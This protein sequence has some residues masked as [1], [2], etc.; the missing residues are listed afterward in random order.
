MWL[1]NC[2]SRGFH[3]SGSCPFVTWAPTLG[4]VVELPRSGALRAE[5]SSTVAGAP[6]PAI[7]AASS[8]GLLGTVAAALAAC[9]LPASAPA[10]PSAPAATAP[11]A[12]GSSKSGPASSSLRLCSRRASAAAT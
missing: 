1:S 11:A 6:T 4:I 10:A 3:R 5:G 7:D 2:G 9:G 8:M 12:A